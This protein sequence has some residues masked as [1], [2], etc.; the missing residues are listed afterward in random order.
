M[1]KSTI[2]AVFLLLSSFLMAQP[3]EQDD[4][5]F[6]PSGIPSLTFS[7]PRFADLDG[8]GDQDLILG[9]SGQS[10]MYF[11]NTGSA[12]SPAFSSGA[13]IFSGV[14]SLNA[15]VGVC[16]DIDADGDLD[17]ITG[18][19]TGI[20][21]YRND[22][23]ATSPDFSI[24]PGVFSSLAVGSNPVPDLADIDDDDDFDLVVGMSE[25]GGVLVYENTGTAQNAQFNQSDM[26]FVGDIGLYAYPVFRDFDG[27]GDQDILCGRD[28]HLFVYYENNGSASN[29][30]WQENA[31]AFSGLGT[32]TYWNSPDLVDLDGDG[33]Y[34]LIYGTAGGPLCYWQNTGS[35]TAP[36]WSENTALFGGVID[37]GGAS[38][39]VFYDFDDDGDLD[40][41][42]GSNLGSIKYY[43]NIGNAN[44]PAWQEDSSLFASIDHSIY[45]AV[46]IG[47]VNDDGYPDAIIGDLSGNLYYHRNNSGLNLVEVPCT[48]TGYSNSGWSS[49][50]LLDMDFDG[51][52]DL[53]VGGEDGEMR[54]LEN[55]GTASEPNWVDISGYFGT[56][57]IG[58]NCVPAFADFDGD[59][60]YD[61]AAGNL[62]GEVTYFANNMG[63]Q[64]NSMLFS[65]MEADQNATPALVDIDADGDLDIVVGCYDGTFSYYRNLEIDGHVLN[66]PRGLYAN[67]GPDVVCYWQEPQEGS[68]SPL[69]GYKV[70]LDGELDG[71]TPNLSWAFF[72]LAQGETYN[73]A[74]TALYEAEE[75]APV[76]IE[77]L[78]ALYFPP[79]NLTYDVSNEYI[80]LNWEEPWE[81]T[82]DLE[83]Y[84]I[85][86]DSELVGSTTELTYDI[87]DPENQHTYYVDVTALYP[88]GVES[89]PVSVDIYF[90]GCTE[91]QAPRKTSLLGNY[92]NPFNPS[93][94]IR[95][96]TEKGGRMTIT[97]FDVRGRKLCNIWDNVVGEGDHSIVWSGRNPKGETLPTGN[98]YYRV[99]FNGQSFMGKMM[100]LK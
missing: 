95:V 60:D 29:P 41:I 93:T 23:T 70:Y 56:I 27:D 3:W 10:P 69:V 72:E 100:L 66:P 90:T 64:E 82:Y 35:G 85:Y 37:V 34:D 30:D 65:E 86:V 68:T 75:S 50:R 42:S 17:L 94:S 81:G 74:V 67:I 20:N 76:Q 58:S 79:N 71:Q 62:F 36:N 28:S 87:L 63:W 25:D 11:E 55:Q 51:D 8:D 16:V 83:S 13:D 31:T 1:K 18:G 24:V 5:V 80:R 38:N 92:P 49:P 99:E 84:R 53:A 52:L 98:Y 9:S 57:D 73:V 89:D 14:S 45:A 4:G 21:F 54:Y 22:G 33:V 44:C 77:F 7:Q 97:L 32:D 88:G 2:I 48:F 47:D 39:P 61:F 15:E 12:S 19:Y 26:T 91:G 43:E 59:G 96:Y 78:Y 6:N 40:M 46:A